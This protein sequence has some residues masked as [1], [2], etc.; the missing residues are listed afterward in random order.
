MTHDR[1][2][3][4]SKIGPKI[5]L[6]IIY[7]ISSMNKLERNVYIFVEEVGEKYSKYLFKK[8]ERNILYIC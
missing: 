2:G 7:Y 1:S 3:L 4:W 6:K 8:V 5:L